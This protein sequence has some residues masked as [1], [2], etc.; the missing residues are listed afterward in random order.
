M[1]HPG[2]PERVDKAPLSA[3]QRG[4]LAQKIKLKEQYQA[5]QKGDVARRLDV[6]NH[7]GRATRASGVVH[8]G[9]PHGLH[10]APYHH[11][12]GHIS[13]VYH[14]SCFE[15]R[16]CGP[17]Y[18]SSVCWYPHWGPWIDWS[19]YYH[20]HP[21]WDPRPVWCRPVV[22]V[23]APVWVYYEVPVWTPLPAVPSGTWVDVEP[24]VVPREQFDLQLLAV[25][26]VDP[27]HPEEKLGPRYRVWFRN[28]SAKPITRPF[29][30]TVVASGDETLRAGLPQAGVRAASIEAGETQAV[31][32]RLPIEVAQLG[33]GANGQPAP[34]RDLHV[35]VDANR[36]V[37]DANR[38][39]NGSR[40]AQAE[41]LPVDPAAFQVDPAKAE[42]GG[43]VVLAGEGLGPEPGK[44]ILHAGGLE[45]EAEILGWYD[46]GVRLTLPKMPLTAATDAELV[47]VRGDGAAAN[48]VQ[49]RLTPPRGGRPA[50]LARPILEPPPPAAPEPVPPPTVPAPEVEP[51]TF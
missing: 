14:H 2:F 38:A 44:V 45:M 41:I 36:E 19:W 25:R 40:V 43:E 9:G 10:P 18:Y 39:N 23:P 12:Y 24:V 42:M 11:L 26:F 50:A 15:F 28:N 5:M 17:A 37:T 27:G 20:C 30:V 49:I 4:E 7:V 29:N 3:A 48:P 33:R 51:P 21:V 13:P 31:D 1:P 35:L 8:V 46:L 34:F 32:I 22:Y 47:V 16:Y 6:A